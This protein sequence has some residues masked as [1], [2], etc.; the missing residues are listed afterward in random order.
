M[1][2]LGMDNDLKTYVQM[3]SEQLR[4]VEDH[5]QGWQIR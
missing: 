3:V 2:R 4:Y 1:L 5:I